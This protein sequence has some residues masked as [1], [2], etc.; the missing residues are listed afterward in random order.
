MDREAPVVG[1]IANHREHRRV[2]NT[3]SERAAHHRHE[4]PVL[5][6]VEALSGRRSVSFAIDATDLA[7][8]RRSDVLGPRKI[9]IVEGH[10]T[11]HR[12]SRGVLARTTRSTVVAH[13]QHRNPRSPGGAHRRET[14][15]T[16][17]RHHHRRPKVGEH[18][19]SLP[20][21]R[22]Q[23][24]QE[25]QVLAEST[26]RAL[27]SRHLEERVRD[28]GRRHQPRFDTPSGTAVIEIGVRAAGVVQRLEDRQ[29]RQHVARGAASGHQNARGHRGCLATFIRSPAAVIEAMSELPPDEMN[30]SVRPVTGKMPTTPPMLMVVC[31]VSQHP[32][33][34]ARRNPKRWAHE[35]A[36]WKAKKTRKPNRVRSPSRT[37]RRRWRR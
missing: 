34:A 25:R 19:A 28:T 10:E 12:A 31:T 29:R 24:G 36:N 17:D 7:T 14:R 16:T 37:P 27:E 15:V 8:H 35:S 33:P 5:G 21:G 9:G 26:P 20:G 2:E 32:M 4:K 23:P 30:G 18:D 11:R 6:N 22:D 3:R 13:D 1:V